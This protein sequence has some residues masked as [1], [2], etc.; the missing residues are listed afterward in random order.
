MPPL[1]PGSVDPTVP[2]SEASQTGNPQENTDPPI[3]EEEVITL[4]SPSGIDLADRA[5]INGDWDTA[6]ASYNE[7]LVAP[8]TDAVGQI[9]A[10]TGIAEAYLAQEQ[11]QLALQP[12]DTIISTYDQASAAQAYFLRGEAK[13]GL[14][15]S[16]GA[17]ADYETYLGLRPGLIDSWVHERIGNVYYA[18][19]NFDEAFRSYARATEAPRHRVGTAQIRE[20]VALLYRQ[21][22]NPERAIEEYNAILAIA[23]NSIYRG[24]IDYA[25]AQALLE[26][27][28][29]DEAYEQL[30][31]VFE[32]YPNNVE[33]LDAL[34]LLLDAGFLVDPYQRGLVD[35]NQGLYAGSIDAFYTYIAAEPID[36]PP[37]AHL[38]IAYAYRELGNTQAALSELQAVIQRFNPDDGVVWGDAW[39]ET[40]DIQASLG[41]TDGA[42]ETLDNFVLNYPSLPQVPTALYQAGQ[43]AASIGDNARAVEYYTQITVEHP[44]DLRGGEGLYAL[45]L[46]AYQVGNYEFALQMFNQV[47]NLPNT[48]RTQEAYLWLGKSQEALGQPNEATASYQAVLTSGSTYTFAAARADD[49][50]NQ[51]PPFAPNGTFTPIADPNQGQ[52]ETEQWLI[53]QFGLTVTPPLATTLPPD[54]ANDPRIIRGQELWQLGLIFD[55]RANFEDIRLTY[56][57]D[58]LASYQLSV[59]FRDIGLYRSSILAARSVHE[60][61][62]IDALQGPEFLARLRYPLYF[63]DLVLP[64]AQQYGLDPLFVFSLIWQESLY[65]GF[66]VSPASAQGL[67]QIWP[68]TGADIA[69]RL[70]W[71]NYD[72][73]DL[74]RPYVSVSFGTW[75]LQEEFRR[76]NQD[77][78]AVLAAYNAGPGNSSQWQQQANG[79]PD[80]FVEVITI[81]EPQLYVT[82]IYEHFQAY[83]ALYTN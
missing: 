76:M 51:A 21:Q 78:F 69:N 11:Y 49:L 28:R 24:T 68:P 75:L 31:F 71:P 57:E 38:F 55:A 16:V 63:S 70:N 3:A 62:G 65:E 25:I 67:M 50:L 66:A 1:N 80:L 64:A 10:Y 7:V 59:Y 9:R 44:E 77:P 79:D 15:D 33:A 39:L 45:G 2:T 4:T 37:D 42:F 27:G 29:T 53:Q 83:Q 14:G 26:A 52:A 82:R 35:Y 23:E 74:S 18:S 19:G 72:V 32:T 36:Y 8:D 5:L 46:D 56:S 60:A 48:I 61:A 6:V 30:T 40:A 58:P 34:L 73:T 81:R 12:L 20:R 43:I 47:A 13:R 22:G 54:L 17:I 41:N